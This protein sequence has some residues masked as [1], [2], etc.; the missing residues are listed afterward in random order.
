MA[1]GDVE[2]AMRKADEEGDEA[3]RRALAHVNGR[4]PSG[5]C[6]G[7]PVAIESDDDG[8]IS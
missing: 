3:M 2:E 6:G 7:G 1:G 5:Q 4:E 8:D